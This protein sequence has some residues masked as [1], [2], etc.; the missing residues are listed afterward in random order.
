MEGDSRPVRRVDNGRNAASVAAGLRGVAEQAWRQGFTVM[1]N[2]AQR[3][4][5]YV[6]M[7]ASLNL[8]TTRDKADTFG[9]TWRITNKGLLYLNETDHD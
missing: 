1:S 5:R 3:H 6:A 7:A 4:M 8:I 2:F 9:R